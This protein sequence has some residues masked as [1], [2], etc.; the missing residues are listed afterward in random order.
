MPQITEV[1]N[2]FIYQ[3]LP[4]TCWKVFRMLEA[5]GCENMLSKEGMTAY[6]KENG[7]LNP[8]ILN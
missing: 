5:F 2:L 6:L 3:K 8:Y 1:T 7:E 4:F